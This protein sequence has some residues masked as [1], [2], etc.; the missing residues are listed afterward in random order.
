MERLDGK[1]A[2]VSGASRGIGKA[3][4]LAYARAGARLVICARGER[5]LRRTADEI[6]STGGVVRWEAVD[7]TKVKDTR[8][9]VRS[10]EKHYGGLDVV[11]NNAGILGPRVPIVGYPLSSWEAVLKNNLTAVF[12][13]CKEALNV[14]IPRRQGSIIN[15]SSGVGRVGRARWGAYAVSKFGVEALTQILAEETREQN[16]RVN[17]V[18]PGGTRTGMRARAYPEED[19]QTLPIPDEITSVFLY[20]G[21]DASTAVTGQSFDARDWLARSR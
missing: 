2:L 21:S 13:V 14:M 3:I 17:A 9:V 4:A 20:L 7:L 6:K 11:V 10:A 8:R 15:V 16:I 12:L 5:D 18:N 19:P 1:A